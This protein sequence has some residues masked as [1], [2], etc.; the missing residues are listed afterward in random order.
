LAHGYHH[1]K[2]WNHW[3]TQALL[4]KYLLDAE[5]H[6]L[7][8]LL[9]KY[10]G[11]HAA[12]IGV[13]EQYRLLASCHLPHHFLITPFVQ[14]KET[15]QNYIESD[16]YELPILSGCCDLVILPHTLELV[17]NPRQL[18]AEACRIIRPEGYIVIC[19]FNPH[20]LW[21][22]YK[23]LSGKNNNL[24]LANHFLETTQIKKWLHLSDFQL[25]KQE[26]ILYRPPVQ[27]LLLREK[28]HF[29]EWLGTKCFPKGGGIYILVARAKVTPLTP[30]RLQWKQ[31]VAGIGMPTT[32]IGHIAK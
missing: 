31:R 19:G 12:L 9:L 1:F 2:N 23:W 22:A 25:E 26:T 21:G 32:T 4:S 6:A 24:S 28:F 30:I 8:K 29:I 3:L 5:Q 20:S 10:Y 18:L 14:E 11:S 7:S 13:P 27:Q 17:D 15:V 16:F